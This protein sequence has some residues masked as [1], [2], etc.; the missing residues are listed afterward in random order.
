MTKSFSR[1][2]ELLPICADRR[3]NDDS[4]CFRNMT[5]K[6][7]LSLL[8]CYIGRVSNGITEHINRKI[9]RY[10]S[11]FN[12]V[13]LSY[14]KP[15]AIQNEAKIMDEQPHIH[16]DITY[17]A[18]VFRPVLGSLLCGTVNKIGVDHVGCLLFDCFNVSVISKGR[19]WHKNGF[20]N[21]FPSGCEYGSCIWFKVVSLDTAGDILSLTGEHYSDCCNSSTSQLH[22]SDTE[23]FIR[24]S[25]KKRK[26]IKIKKK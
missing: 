18:Y 24:N 16:F 23:E 17:T 3:K 8:P 22:L 4:S 9:L 2:P 21:T 10:S 20:S 15:R 13:L 25:A 6:E 19:N 12:G 7:H 26:R 14:S 5:V 1:I 11:Q